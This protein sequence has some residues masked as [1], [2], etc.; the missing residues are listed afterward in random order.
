MSKDELLAEAEFL[1]RQAADLLEME[2]RAV[3]PQEL[4]KLSDMILKELGNA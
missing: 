1:M 4:R 3:M 2:G